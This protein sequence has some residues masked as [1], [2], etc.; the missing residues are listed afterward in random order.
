MDHYYEKI[1]GWFNFQPLYYVAA[2]IFPDGSNFLEIG[3]WKGASASFMGVELI[4]L[5]K[6][7]T[8]LY[9]IDTWEGTPG[10]HDTESA[11]IEKTL[12]EQ[13]LTNTKP[14]NDNGLTIVPIKSKS[15]DCASVFQD[16]FFDFIYIDGSH[17]YEDVKQDIIK[18]LPKLKKDGIFAGHDWQC[19][20]VVRAVSETLGIS[21]IRLIHN[22]WIYVGKMP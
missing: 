6:T 13:F 2:N 7:N 22:T 12:L 1:Q 4:N 3:S 15:Q 16:N 9:C 17:Y 21:N 19:E 18:Y 14:L 10:E 5:K 8:K 20:E 11:V